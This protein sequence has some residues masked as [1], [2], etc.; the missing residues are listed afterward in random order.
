MDV[1]SWLCR[2]F[3]DLWSYQSMFLMTLWVQW[4]SGARVW[5]DAAPPLTAAVLPDSWSAST[6]AT[7][8]SCR[9]AARWGRTW[10][11][12]KENWGRKSW[13]RMKMERRSWSVPLPEAVTP[14]QLPNSNCLQMKARSNWQTSSALQ[15]LMTQEEWRSLQHACILMKPSEGGGKEK[16]FTI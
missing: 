16:H 3:W 15:K 4:S 14:P 11:F 1:D 5:H 12:L 8:P 10:R 9:T 13:P 6:T 7:C 2:A